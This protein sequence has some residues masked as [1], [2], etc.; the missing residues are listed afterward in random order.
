M[1]ITFEGSPPRITV[2]LPIN[3]RMQ[4]DTTIEREMTQRNKSPM[5][6][7]IS[8]KDF[9]S[10]ISRNSTICRSHNHLFLPTFVCSTDS[11]STPAA[12]ICLRIL[13]RIVKR[14][15]QKKKIPDRLPLA[16][17][18]EDFN[19]AGKAIGENMFHGEAYQGS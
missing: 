19:L 12:A 1:P 7:P 3:S 11:T 10:A 5:E 16:N 13:E 6:N 15:R 8:R 14:P 9:G 2:R 4:R 17:R 18:K